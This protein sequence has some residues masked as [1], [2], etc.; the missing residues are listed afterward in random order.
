MYFTVDS[1]CKFASLQ[2]CKS[3]FNVLTRCLIV[4]RITCLGV[5]I[6]KVFLKSVF[7]FDQGYHFKWII[8]FPESRAIP[9]LKCI[10]FEIQITKRCRRVALRVDKV[11]KLDR[12]LNHVGKFYPFAQ[13]RVVVPV[14]F[15]TFLLSIYFGKITKKR[16]FCIPFI[17]MNYI[18]IFRTNSYVQHFSDPEF[19]AKEFQIF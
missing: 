13:P 5:G 14:S 1:F 16:N 19:W 7:S 8:W 12:D 11:R 9:F 18:R 10:F 6:F 2:V 3:A 17:D 15:S 4:K